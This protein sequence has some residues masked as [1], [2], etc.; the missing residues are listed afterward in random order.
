MGQRCQ[1]GSERKGCK[2][3]FPNYKNPT[4]CFGEI[5]I[6]LPTIVGGKWGW[7]GGVGLVPLQPFWS[8]SMTN[9]K[10]D[11]DHLRR[12]PKTPDLRCSKDLFSSCS[13]PTATDSGLGQAWQA[14]ILR[15]FAINTSG[16][17]N[18]L[19]KHSDYRKES[20][21]ESGKV[22]QELLFIDSEVGFSV[23]SL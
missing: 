17:E 11:G 8:L 12:V 3:E 2:A 4:V 20:Q 15:S 14:V 6:G 1:S 22:G 23:K 5:F 21:R 10:I 16:G 7:G 19:I 18:D 9:D 13:F